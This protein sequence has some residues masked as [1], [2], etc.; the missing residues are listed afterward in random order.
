MKKDYF[1]EME[2]VWKEFDSA[3]DSYD[4]KALKRLVSSD[5]KLS[6]IPDLRRLF[7]FIKEM[8]KHTPVPQT[9]FDAIVDHAYVRLN[10]IKC[11]SCKKQMMAAYAGW[12]MFGGVRSACPSC[13]KLFVFPK[14]ADPQEANYE[15]GEK[16]EDFIWTKETFRR[17]FFE[18]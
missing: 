12:E 7:F 3:I 13:K 11:P 14:C 1:K 16:P 9:V 8:E 5:R 15:E 4:V 18:E 17:Y 6:M 2:E 10:K